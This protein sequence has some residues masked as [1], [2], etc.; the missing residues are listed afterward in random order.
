MLSW[1]GDTSSPDSSVSEYMHFA[2]VF[3][4]LLLSKK[5]LEATES[6]LKAKDN[7]MFGQKFM[8][9]SRSLLRV[10]AWP[11]GQHTQQS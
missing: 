6:F 4:L 8:C 11:R 9:S 5:S 7:T 10:L 1:S 3:C 2:I